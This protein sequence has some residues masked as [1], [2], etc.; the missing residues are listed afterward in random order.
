MHE[1]LDRYGRKPGWMKR[2]FVAELRHKKEVWRNWKQG[3]GNLAGSPR[4]ARVKLGKPH[5]AGVETT[6][7]C[8]GQQEGLLQVS[9]LE[10]KV[11]ANVSL[12]L[13]I[14]SKLERT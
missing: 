4:Y 3:P 9:S 12:L 13:N 8:R 6:K 14:A 7:E 5:T 2:E 11:K 1:K 10:R